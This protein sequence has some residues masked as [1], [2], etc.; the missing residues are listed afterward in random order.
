MENI[1][2]VIV[3]WNNERIIMDCLNSIIKYTDVVDIVVVDSCSTDKTVEVIKESNIKKV[4]VIKLEQNVGFAKGN[5]IGVIEAKCENVLLLNPDTIF[6]EKGLDKLVKSLNSDVGIV[7]CKL[8]NTDKSLQPSTYNFDTPVN[9]IL[10]QF[11]LG[12]LLPNFLRYSC[13]PYLSKHD[14]IF[15]PDWVIGAFMMIKKELFLRVDGFSEDYFLYSEDMDICKKVSNLGFR[16][17]YNPTFAIIHLGGESEKNDISSSKQEK[18]LDSKIIYSRKYSRKN[19]KYL[20]YCYKIKYF[21][22]SLFCGSKD[23]KYFFPKN[24]LVKKRKEL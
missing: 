21:L 22:C 6:I 15:Y 4:K 18:L 19:F 24:Y 14:K 8:L 2:V 12:K 20:L 13:A 7:G 11:M 1:S 3:T 17:E 10:E 5:N 23:N 16:I 9:I